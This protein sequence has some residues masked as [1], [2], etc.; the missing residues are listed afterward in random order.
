[1]LLRGLRPRS[2]LEIGTSNGYSTIWLADALDEGA[3]LVSVDNDRG[4]M[5]EAR[6]NLVRAGFADRVDLVLGDGGEVLAGTAPGSVDFCLLD[7]ER[8]AYAGYWPD[9]RRILA[10]RALAV[11]DNCVSHAGDVAGFRRLVDGEPS[12][13]AVL[14]PV[15][16]GLLFIQKAG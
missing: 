5:A 1:M 6:A 14:V 8:P 13:D 4:R 7:A 9:V 12:T 2:V 15:G 16:A 10:P 3:R 11:V